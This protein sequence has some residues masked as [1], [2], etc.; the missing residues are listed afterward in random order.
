MTIIFCVTIEHKDKFLFTC[1]PLFYLYSF[2]LNIIN[3]L[4]PYIMGSLG[5]PEII[6]ILVWLAFPIISAN[7]GAK[8]N[9]GATAGFFLGLFIGIFG[10]IIVLCSDKKQDLSY[11]QS[12]SVPDQLKKYKD[13]LD[14]GAITEAEYNVQKDRLLNQ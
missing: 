14:S 11:F 2:N 1:L 5:A 8:R 12:P 13:L 4:K 7:V 3:Q 10:L 9:I 6:L